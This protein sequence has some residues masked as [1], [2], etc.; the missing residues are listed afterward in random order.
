MSAR[1]EDPTDYSD[2]VL[3]LFPSLS[4]KVHIFGSHGEAKSSP[5]SRSLTLHTLGRMTPRGDF[6]HKTFLSLLIDSQTISI[7]GWE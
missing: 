4:F 3:A 5:P 2:H 1:Q 6:T 7:N